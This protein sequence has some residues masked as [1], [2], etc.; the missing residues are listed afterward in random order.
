LLI[1]GVFFDLYGTILIPKNNKKAWD[2]WFLTFLTL[3]RDKGLRLSRRNFAN[4]CSGFF[5]REEPAKRDKNLT[6]YENR[7]RNFANDLRLS[8]KTYEIKNIAHECVISWH[9]YVKI[10]PDAIP[11]LKILRNEKNLALITNFDHPPFLY[12][13]LSKYKLIEY[14]EFIAISGEIG[15]KKPDPQIFNITLEK[16][17]LKP[18]EVLF[19][20]D[21][22]EDIEGALKAGIKPILIRRQ[23]LKKTIIGNDY[24]SK[25]K[26]KAKEKITKNSKMIPFKTISHLKE[27]YQI[28]NL[29]STF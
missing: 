28:L 13:I 1:K 18:L 27:L 23:N 22:K 20:G 26:G 25:K 19:I 8:L 12:S 4:I 10:D 17:K 5:T 7:I 16:L 2:N 9:K 24:Y 3:M 6:I 21:S 15:Y 29:Q 11:L 14:F